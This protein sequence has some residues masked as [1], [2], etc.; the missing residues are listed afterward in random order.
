M[1]QWTRLNCSNEQERSRKNTTDMLTLPEKVENADCEKGW[2]SISMEALPEMLGD[3]DYL[4]PGIRGDGVDQGKD[5][6]SKSVWRKLP[7]V[8][9]G[10]VYQYLID[11]FY[12]QDP[13][14]LNYQLELILD[15]L[16]SKK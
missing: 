10:K 6:E 11:D 13:I 16:I 1:P 2:A 12:F 5:I 9:A 15:F 14:A 8:K 4:M 7:A 3:A